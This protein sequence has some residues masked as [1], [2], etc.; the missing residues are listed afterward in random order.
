MPNDINK[1]N[2]LDII[3]T[4]S[5]TFEKNKKIVDENDREALRARLTELSS[6]AGVILTDDYLSDGEIKEE[7]TTEKTDSDT[8]L[9]ENK[10]EITNLKDQIEEINFAIE[11]A[12][13]AINKAKIKEA[14]DNLTATIL[15]AEGILPRLVDFEAKSI[16]TLG[17]NKGRQVNDNEDAT[18]EELK[19]ANVQ[20]ISDIQKAI[21]LNQ[22]NAL[23]KQLRD[24]NKLLKDAKNNADEIVGIDE[25]QD[26]RNRL[27]AAIESTEENLKNN[28]IDA[29]DF[30]V[31]TKALKD[32]LDESKKSIE[33]FFSENHK[34]DLKRAIFRAN[35]LKN[36]ISKIPE[37]AN[38]LTRLNKIISENPFN[39]SDPDATVLEKT[40]KLK[41]AYDEILAKLDKYNAKKELEELIKEA[42]ALKAEGEKEKV[43]AAEFKKAID[44]ANNGIGSKSTETLENDFDTLRVSINKYREKLETSRKAKALE[45]I[46][47]LRTKAENELLNNELLDENL[48]R[49]LKNIYDLTSNLNGLASAQLNELADSLKQKEDEAEKDILTKGINNEIS[50]FKEKIQTLENDK[51]IVS[52]LGTIQ[53]GL[54]TFVNE[55]ENISGLSNEALKTRLEEIKTKKADVLAKEKQEWKNDYEV[56]KQNAKNI[57]SMISNETENHHKENKD[58]LNTFL[59]TANI[60]DTDSTDQIKDKYKQLVDKRNEIEKAEKDQHKR[61]INELLA[62]VEKVD[63]KF[64]DLNMNN[65][66]VAL[67]TVVKQKA[68][69]EEALD[70]KSITELI[71]SRDRIKNAILDAKRKQL[72]ELLRRADELKNSLKANHIDTAEIER[73]INSAKNPA[74]SSQNSS[75]LDDNIK[76]VSDIIG[77]SKQEGDRVRDLRDEITRL[78][79]RAKKVE[80]KTKTTQ[81]GNELTG[82]KNSV[83]DLNSKSSTELTAIRDRLLAATNSAEND[84]RANY[85]EKIQNLLNDNKRI[86]ANLKTEKLDTDLAT[87]QS[88]IDA[89]NHVNGNND[90]DNLVAEEAKLKQA[91]ADAENKLLTKV[92]N[93]INTLAGNQ[94]VLI[95]ELALINTK[96]KDNLNSVIND[97]KRNQN[98]DYNGLKNKQSLLNNAIELANSKKALNEEIKK[99]EALKAKMQPSAGLNSETQA[100]GKKIDAAKAKLISETNDANVKS[101]TA[102]VKQDT[103]TN[104]STFDEYNRVKKEVK[105]LKTSTEA[106]INSNL[107]DDKFYSALK[108]DLQSV[109]TGDINTMNLE[110]LKS[111]KD[112]ITRRKDAVDKK[113]KQIKALIKTYN[114]VKRKADEYY[115]LIRELDSSRLPYENEIRTPANNKYEE[116]KRDNDPTKLQASIDIYKK[117]EAKYTELIN[118]QK[119][120]LEKELAKFAPKSSEANSY[121]NPGATDSTH[122]LPNGR[123]VPIDNLAQ[124]DF[125]RLSNDFKANTNRA[126]ADRLYG[127]QKLKTKELADLIISKQQTLATYDRRKKEILDANFDRASTF[128]GYVNARNALYDKLYNHR[129]DAD[130]EFFSLEKE[131]Y[132]TLKRLSNLS[133]KEQDSRLLQARRDLEAATRKIELREIATENERQK[134]INYLGDPNSSDFDKYYRDFRTDF[135]NWYPEAKRNSTLDKYP[136]TM[137]DTMDRIKTQLLP[138]IKNFAKERDSLFSLR[139]AYEMKR[140]IQDYG[141]DWKAFGY[142]WNGEY[143]RKVF[144]QNVQNPQKTR[145][146]NYLQNIYNNTE[147]NIAWRNDEARNYYAAGP[148]RA[149]RF[150]ENNWTKYDP[151][152]YPY[153]YSVDA[154]AYQVAEVW[155]YDGYSYIV[156]QML[157]VLVPSLRLI[158]DGTNSVNETNKHNIS[159]YGYI[160]AEVKRKW[161]NIYE[162][163]FSP[164]NTRK[165]KRLVNQDILEYLYGQFNTNMIN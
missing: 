112:S 99:A 150:K 94:T 62:E 89:N 93:D 100:F 87:L 58:A 19:N 101:L 80:G 77:S 5:L 70:K 33:T 74:V 123:P 47:A 52:N 46:K 127:K 160:N 1:G 107:N 111:K 39:D 50:L 165:D 104:Q 147:N 119:T 134:Y 116:F 145:F 68:P 59:S 151:A 152:G 84:A 128:G 54:Q 28:I 121:T 63:S 29:N 76:K 24:I 144:A 86:K 27:L 149:N 105:A 81:I 69:S 78:L 57:A 95:N 75:Q 44:A 109:L 114:D 163:Y 20:L 138:L 15:R 143:M 3:K 72:T 53:S 23:S 49:E 122:H 129:N 103:A 2:Y 36:D 37:L 148:V 67:D 43:D 88:V 51:K 55:K 60:L 139:L 146:I 82:A 71:D 17:I 85:R 130:P 156:K 153:Y 110:A 97:A 65:E 31:A 22:K 113:A 66:K 42:N 64:D 162:A 13:D 117:A 155:Y 30:A 41:E 98:L 26:A 18:A 132:N 96:L 135:D 14:R 9:K 124:G 25:L 6:S 140:F 10:P 133:D 16:L 21:L 32:V 125:R 102:S 83:A 157:R 106:Y 73:V 91:F 161:K 141:D 142:N 56:Q 131:T 115:D 90:I 79:A 136:D 8:L 137:K 40:R 7:L 11:K 118:V 120:G 164:I 4:L 35:R 38:D 126:D 154:S 108:A 159:S 61:E 34:E 12:K 92:R 48:K 158:R 45:R